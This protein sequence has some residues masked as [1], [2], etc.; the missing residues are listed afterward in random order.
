MHEVRHGNLDSGALVADFISSPFPFPLPLPPTVSTN[1][2]R[3]E[4]TRLLLAACARDAD[5]SRDLQSFFLLQGLRHRTAANAELLL[6]L[7]LLLLLFLP[8]P[9]MLPL[10]LT[11]MRSGTRNILDGGL[12]KSTW[13]RIHRRSR[14]PLPQPSL[15]HPFLCGR[16]RGLHHCIP[17]PISQSQS[18]SHSTIAAAPWIDRMTLQNH[19]PAAPDANPTYMSSQG[20]G[21]AR[22]KFARRLVQRVSLKDAYT[23]HRSQKLRSLSGLQTYIAGKTISAKANESVTE[24]QTNDVVRD[25]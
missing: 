22:G 12:L 2:P 21:K 18:Q 6:V 11:A 10:D 20:Q 9:M 14:S 25:F 13:R 16:E 15:T 1:K 19:T 17:I 5:I 23:S 4:L 24:R 7:L 8:T 3:N